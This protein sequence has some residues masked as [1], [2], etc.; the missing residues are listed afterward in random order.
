MLEKF[1]EQLLPSLYAAISAS[2]DATAQQLGYLTLG[3]ALVQ[4]LFSPVGG[5][6]GACRSS[7]VGVS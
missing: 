2:F 7:L 6:A 1:D 4:A 5:L 3:R